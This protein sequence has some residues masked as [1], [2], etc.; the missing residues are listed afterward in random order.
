MAKKGRKLALKHAAK[1]VQNQRKAKKKSQI[2]RKGQAP[3]LKPAIHKPSGK[4]KKQKQP[5]ASSQQPGKPSQDAAGGAAPKPSGCGP[6]GG[7]EDIILLVGEGGA[8][9]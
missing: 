1:Q 6:Y 3:Q 8:V 9:V 7:T 4:P 2:F 5:S